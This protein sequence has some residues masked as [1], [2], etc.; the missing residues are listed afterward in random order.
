MEGGRAN[1][2]LGKDG[3]KNDLN[4]LARNM[5]LNFFQPQ[6]SSLQDAFCEDEVR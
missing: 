2:Q 1:L 4:D 3:S 6:F 5:L